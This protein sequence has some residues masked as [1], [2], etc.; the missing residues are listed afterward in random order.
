MFNPNELILEKIRAVEEYD[1]ATDELVGRYTQ[2]ESPSLQTSTDAADVTDAM[3]TPIH[4]FYRNSQGTFSFTNSLHSLDLMATQFGGEKQVADADSKILVPVSETITIASDA[5]VTLK[6]KPAGTKGSEVKYVKLI[7][8]S[9]TFGDT[10]TVSAADASGKTF[11]LDAETKKITLP[12]GTTGRVFVSYVR[13]SDAAVKISKSTNALPP[14]RKLVIH[15]IFHDPCDANIVY[16]GIIQCPRAQ[17]DPTSVEVGLAS[18]SKQAAS[19]KLK[20]A[21]C[22]ESATLF[23]VIVAAE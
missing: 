20:K 1:P 15:A 2:I 16:A 23:D 4:T 8:A 18:D 13:E 6:Y 17:I 7:N 11:T 9:N 14:V 5:T 3:G 22:D 10:Y 19:Y 21:Y 12:Q